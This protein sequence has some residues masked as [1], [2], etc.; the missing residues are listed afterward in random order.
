MLAITLCG[1][2]RGS[3]LISF[4]IARFNTSPSDFGVFSS[5][6]ERP[7]L[8]QKPTFNDISS[9]TSE[10]LNVEDKER[11]LSKLDAFLSAQNDRSMTYKKQ[12]IHQSSNSDLKP[13]IL[14]QDINAEMDATQNT[15]VLPMTNENTDSKSDE[16]EMETNSKDRSEENEVSVDDCAAQMPYMSLVPQVEAPSQSF[17]L[18]KE[19]ISHLPPPKPSSSMLHKFPQKSENESKNKEDSNEG[20]LMKEMDHS[21]DFTDSSWTESA[22]NPEFLVKK[23]HSRNRI[24]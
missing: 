7:P 5:L 14:N 3:Q 11:A 23:S 16:V 21:I 9:Q 1:S 2:P 10:S 8:P 20:K 22:K 4:L 24:K 15:K 6:P 17:S 12:I 18:S 13:Q 19:I